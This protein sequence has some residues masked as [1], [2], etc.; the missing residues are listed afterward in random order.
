MRQESDS[1]SSCSTAFRLA[2]FNLVL[3]VIVCR[4]QSHCHGLRRYIIVQLVRFGP[5]VFQAEA[6][7]LGLVV[8]HNG[9]NRRGGD[10]LVTSGSRQSNQ[11]VVALSIS[12]TSR[13]VRQ[14]ASRAQ[15]SK[16]VSGLDV[17]TS[18]DTNGAGREASHGRP[19]NGQV[20][21]CGS[22]GGVKAGV[23]NEK[24]RSS[25]VASRV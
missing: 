21:V 13:K 7:G 3:P 9:F 12:V 4:H 19:G 14:C 18:L 20:V 24:S 17:E 25:F 23:H 16:L 8:K 15:I 2:D 1:P 6:T 22:G 10:N 5:S 11:K